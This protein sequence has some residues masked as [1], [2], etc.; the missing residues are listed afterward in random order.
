MSIDQTTN[1]KLFR[2]IRD[3][4]N[5]IIEMDRTCV[6]RDRIEQH[7]KIIYRLDAM[8]HILGRVITDPDPE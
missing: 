8:E 7:L 3:I 1:D 5:D 4:K 6:D 2:H